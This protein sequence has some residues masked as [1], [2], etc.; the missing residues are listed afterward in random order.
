MLSAP[1]CKIYSVKGSELKAQEFLE[2]IQEDRE[3]FIANAS[4]S[5]DDLHLDQNTK[6]KVISFLY[7]SN[8]IS[9]VP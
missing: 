1:I 7:N 9:K 3:S 2:F 6:V 8:L 4:A 5:F